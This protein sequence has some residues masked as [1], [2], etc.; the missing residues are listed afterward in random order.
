MLYARGLCHSCYYDPLVRG[1]F[2]K[3]KKEQEMVDVDNHPLPKTPTTF[4]PGTEE[5]QVILR[6]RAGRQESLHHPKDKRWED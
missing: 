3:R 1:Q 4:E 5:K 2:P 6:Q